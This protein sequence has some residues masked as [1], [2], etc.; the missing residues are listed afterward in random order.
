MPSQQYNKAKGTLFERGVADFLR[1]CG[2]FPSCERAPRWGSVDK[3]DLVNTG[4]FCFELKATKSIDLAGFITEAEV[5]CQNAG[6]DYPIV[7]VKRRQK[8]ISASYVVMTLT[9]WCDRE[10]ELRSAREAA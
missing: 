5:E 4:P 6:K 10:L 8:P 1:D 3:G 9:D 7:V 2:V